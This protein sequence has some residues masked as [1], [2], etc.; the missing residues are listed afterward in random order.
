MP[1]KDH[2]IHDPVLLRRKAEEAAEALDGLSAGNES[3]PHVTHAGL[4]A[5]KSAGPGEKF[6]Q[7]RDYDSADRPQDIDWRQS[8]KGDRIFIRQKERQVPQTVALWCAGGRR[9]E[10]VSRSDLLS[11]ASCAQ[12]LCLAAGILLAREG[13][14]IA[15]AGTDGRPGHSENTLQKAAQFLTGSPHGALPEA[16]LAHTLP[17]GAYLLAAGDFLEDLHKIEH[18]FDSCAIPSGNALLVQI[19]DPAEIDLPYEG[20]AIFRDPQEGTL[21]PVENAQSLRQEYIDRIASHIDGLKS[22]CRRRHWHYVF[23]T[24]DAPPAQALAQIR[25]AIGADALSAGVWAP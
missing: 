14:R 23:H 25:A 16:S 10:W 5:R 20:R 21:V 13:E 6:W 11:K 4:H 7:Y 1:P 9:M 22:L 18:A 19:L 12:I 8:A 17:N 3:R 2:R 15:V 24:T